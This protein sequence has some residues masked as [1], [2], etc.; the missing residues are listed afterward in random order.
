MEKTE[1]QKILKLLNKRGSVTYKEEYLKRRL[2]ERLRST[3]S[4]NY[5]EYLDYL[6]LNPNEIEFVLKRLSINVTWFFRNFETFKYLQEVLESY[7]IENYKATGKKVFRIWSSGSAIGAEAYTLAIIID[8]IISNL[9]LKLN[10]K[11]IGTDFNED[12]LEIAKTGKYEK[13]YLEDLPK[14][15]QKKYFIKTK[16][17]QYQIKDFIQKKV[18]FHYLDLRDTEY[19]LRE[20][21]LIVCRNVLIY[22]DDESQ[23]EIIKKFHHCAI[24][25]GLLLLGGSEIISPELEHYW[26]AIS[27]KH[28][29]YLKLTQDE[30]PKQRP[31]REKVI[32]EKK[33]EKKP[34]TAQRRRKTTKK[35]KR[36]LYDYSTCIQ[37]NRKF[38][39][40]LKYEIHRE[41]FHRI[42]PRKKKETFRK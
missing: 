3:K 23:T 18:L 24:P 29:I 33:I 15:I 39:S 1:F 42:L 22:F 32:K 14:T 10:I 41:I 20:I 40:R 16:S 9:Q 27:P 30:T 11:I 35:K 21:D 2:K 17:N 5:T 31:I 28:R 13:L 6:A 19:L 38:A 26:K 36:P 37:C 8:N 7:I 34:L 25:G 4:A 12:L